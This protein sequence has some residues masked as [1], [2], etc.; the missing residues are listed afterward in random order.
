MK[1]NFL[2]VIY[3]KWSLCNAQLLSH[4][5]VLVGQSESENH[6]RR[7]LGLMKNAF[8]IFPTHFYVGPHNRG[9]LE[10]LRFFR[11]SRETRQPRYK[12]NKNNKINC[13]LIFGSRS[14]YIPAVKNATFCSYFYIAAVVFRSCRETLFG[15]CSKP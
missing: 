2:S 10:A 1:C 8:T 6:S 3:N 9:Y 5:D 4:L 15:A 7:F 12:N 11:G 13:K 14:S